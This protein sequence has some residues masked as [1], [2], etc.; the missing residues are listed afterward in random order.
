[1]TDLDPIAEPQDAEPQDFD[2]LKQEFMKHIAGNW[3]KLVGP[4]TISD[5]DANA[6]AKFKQF[7]VYTE[8]AVVIASKYGPTASRQTPALRFLSVTYVKSIRVPFPPMKRK[9]NKC[10]PHS[11]LEARNVVVPTALLWLPNGH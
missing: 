10:W 4:N 1:M 11:P 2:A 8:Y 7:N 3:K 9:K 5:P 6:N